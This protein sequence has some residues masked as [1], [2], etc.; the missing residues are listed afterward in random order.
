MKRL[1]EKERIIGIYSS[2]DKGPLLFVTAAVH[3]NEPSGVRALE[4]IFE[5]LHAQ[6]P[7][8]KGTLI[9]VVGNKSALD[10]DVRFLDEDLNRTWTANNIDNK[11]TDSNEKRE[12]F[13]LIE[14]LKSFDEHEHSQR[15]FI[16]CH[17]TSSESLP[18]ISVQDVGENN[19]WAQQFPIHIIKGFSDIVQGTIDGYLSHQGMT[20]FTV[21]AG[22]HNSS[23]S[24]AYHEGI[25]WIA[26]EKS[27]N[28]NFED[29]AEMPNAVLKTIND[30]PPQKT[31]EI[32]HRF[33]LEANDDFKM[34]AGFENF[35]RIKKGEPL[36]TFNG[37]D[38]KS[39]WDA[40]IF[41]PLYQAKGNDG[42]FVVKDI[43]N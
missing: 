37:K 35:Q 30:T 16:D 14:L 27:C 8:I 15:Y 6:K 2:N 38:I 9:G 34:L 40:Y 13:E 39:S 25:I 36:A 3:G 4:N 31:L 29:L 11:I 7:P 23:D 19:S 20:G 12:M 41:M 1:T 43:E 33:G 42:F 28:L 5:I 21:E 32:I 10:K 22:Q 18:Y 17:T 26:L 24:E